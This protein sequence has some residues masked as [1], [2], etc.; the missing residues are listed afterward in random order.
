[1]YANQQMSLDLVVFRTG[2]NQ[3]YYAAWHYFTNDTLAIV[4]EDGYFF[5]TA[6]APIQPSASIR[7]HASDGVKNLQ[8]VVDAQA[9][10]VIKTIPLTDIGQPYI[11]L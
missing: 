9:N 8:F 4:Q 6:E 5:D 7:V 1:M 2:A 10:N 3:P 11:P